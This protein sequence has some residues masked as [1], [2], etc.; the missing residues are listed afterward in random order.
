MSV[1][2]TLRRPLLGLLLD[3]VGTRPGRGRTDPSGWCLMSRLWRPHRRV[4][5]GS[6][7]EN[8]GDRRHGHDVEVQGPFAG[9]VD[10]VGGVAADWSR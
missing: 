7:F 2:C 3:G 9:R 1:I 8:R 4:V 5:L 10:R 6:A